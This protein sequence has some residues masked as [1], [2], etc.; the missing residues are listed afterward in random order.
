MYYSFGLEVS[1]LSNV[2]QRYLLKMEDAKVLQ[3]N[4]MEGV[5]LLTGA[6][7]GGTLPLCVKLSVVSFFLSYPIGCDQYRVI[8]Q[9]WNRT[10][11][12]SS[13]STLLPLPMLRV[14]TR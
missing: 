11:S 12:T 7:S 3:L 8:V 9:R 5:E 14:S 6:L 2:L 1:S 13:H 4:T 10:S